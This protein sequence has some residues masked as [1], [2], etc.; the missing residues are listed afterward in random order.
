MNKHRVS[1]LAL[2][3]AVV[4]LICFSSVKGRTKPNFDGTWRMNVG[5]SKFV[6]REAPANL[7]IRFESKGTTLRRL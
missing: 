5:K 4:F 6:S 2:A 7:E 1:V 3:G